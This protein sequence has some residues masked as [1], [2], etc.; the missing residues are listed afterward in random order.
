[1]RPG[2]R[3]DN[4]LTWVYPRTSRGCS[5]TGVTRFS[6][7]PKLHHWLQVAT[8]VLL[9][10]Q[11]K[12]P[13]AWSEVCAE[14]ALQSLIVRNW[15]WHCGRDEI[16]HGRTGS[17]SKDWVAISCLDYRWLILYAIGPAINKMARSGGPSSPDNWVKSARPWKRFGLSGR[18]FCLLQN[19]VLILPKKKELHTDR[20]YSF[21]MGTWPTTI[22]LWLCL[23]FDN[24]VLFTIP[25]GRSCYQGREVA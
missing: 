20:Q 8:M 22:Q 21:D 23:I 5:H 14:V 12:M 3:I 1:M 7:A 11:K 24:V 19:Y 2:P 25:A 16:D 6:D 4:D 15:G 13:S 17:C 9:Y 10:P 18:R